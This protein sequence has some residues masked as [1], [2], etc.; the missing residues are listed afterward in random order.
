[1]K[2]LSFEQ[3]LAALEQTVEQMEG[4]ELS[5]EQAMAAYEKAVAL[6]NRCRAH[7]SQFEGRLTVLTAEGEQPL[8]FKSNATREVFGAETDPDPLSED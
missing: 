4:D 7:L 1:M 6:L 5:L 8:E 3:A 2:E